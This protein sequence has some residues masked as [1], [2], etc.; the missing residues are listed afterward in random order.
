MNTETKEN[1]DLAHSEFTESQAGS[2][3]AERVGFV[4]TSAS[5]IT[6]AKALNNHE[7]RIFAR[8]YERSM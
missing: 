7:N 2:R 8:Q 6:S 3:I 5:P 1:K 4:H